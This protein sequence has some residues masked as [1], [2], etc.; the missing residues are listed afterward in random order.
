MCLFVKGGFPVGTAFLKRFSLRSVLV[1][2]VI[3]PLVLAVTVISYAGLGV[4]EYVVEKRMQKD[5]E[6][7]ARAIRLPVSYSLEK[8]RSGSVGQAL[9]SVFHIDRVYGAYVYDPNGRR[10][11]AVGAVEP[12]QRPHDLIEMV[13]DGKRK[14]QYEKIEGRRVY[15]YF[16]PLFDTAGK[17]NGLLKVTRKKS[18]FENYI[19]KLRIGVTIMLAGLGLLISGLVLFGFDRAAGRYFAQLANSMTKVRAGDRSHRSGA[20]GPRE[21]ATLANALNAMLDSMD[22]S[23]KEVMARRK[24]QQA[25]ED[26]LRQNE[27]MAAIGRLAAGVAHELGAPLS[28]IDGKAQRCLRDADIGPAHK[29]S[30]CAIRHQVQRM[31][32]IVRQLLDFGKGAMRHKRRIHVDR[33]AES[34]VSSI[35]KEIGD[36]IAFIMRGPKPGPSLYVDPLRLEQALINLL[37]NA[38]QAEKTSRVELHWKTSENHEIIFE[39]E[40]D[41]EGIAE[42]IKSK[43]FEPFFSTHKTARNTGM[44]LS[45]VHGIIREHGGVIQI[46]DSALG[47][48]GFRITLPPQTEIKQ[49]DRG[50]NHG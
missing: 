4:M 33:L 21:I 5:V 43:I 39:V 28:L 30:L 17:S 11:A 1:I 37:R 41:G 26:R 47:G 18:D 24:A 19:R 34:A 9:E 48:A 36:K 32:D 15:S 6:L 45:V 50:E 44:G 42:E 46:F 8:D 35:R 10:V 13:E 29:N 38:A 49:T 31:S 16:V 3:I 27:K 7:V 12:D 23:E 40:D 22:R 14:G 2:N 20:D 25:L